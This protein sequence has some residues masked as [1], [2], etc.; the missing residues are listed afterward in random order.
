MIIPIRH[1]RP[2]P[3]HG[4]SGGGAARP[5]DLVAWTDPA[6]GAVHAGLL[7]E[8]VYRTRGMALVRGFLGRFG[9]DGSEHRQSK[10]V[11]LADCVV[12]RRAATHEVA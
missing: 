9:R 3:R 8:F 4:E 7:V 2:Q 12:T 1:P 6:N 11:A 5:G 10:A